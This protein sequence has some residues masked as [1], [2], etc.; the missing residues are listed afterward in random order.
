LEE[1]AVHSA[2]CA[3]DGETF[4][5]VARKA[6]ADSDAALTLATEGAFND[7]TDYMRFIRTNATG[8]VTPEA[9]DRLL[10]A[11]RLAELDHDIAEEA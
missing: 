9:F 3:P 1:R 8:P 7:F 10:D 11:W 2:G 6:L 5:D 4:A